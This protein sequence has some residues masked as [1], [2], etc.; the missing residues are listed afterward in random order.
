MFKKKKELQYDENIVR[1]GKPYEEDDFSF[2]IRNTENSVLPMGLEVSD[3]RYIIIDGKYISMYALF[4]LPYSA[5]ESFFDEL[6]NL[7]EGIE[8]FIKHKC[9]NKQK[10]IKEITQYIG[11]TKVKIEEGENQIDSEVMNS[12]L[13]HSQYLKKGLANGNEFYYIYPIVRVIADS[14]EELKKKDAK[15]ESLLSGKDITAKRADFKN[16]ETFLTAIPALN[17]DKGI[18]NAVE[19]NILSNDLAGLYPFTNASISDD[20]GIYLGTNM[21][22]KSNV[23]I[24]LFNTNKYMNANTLIFGGSGSGKT[25]TT[26][27]IMLRMRME[28][29]PV[30]MIAPFKGFEYKN[31]CMA[32]DGNYIKF[33]AGS[34]LGLNIMDIR[35]YQSENNESYLADKI[36]F[37]KIILDMMI[38]EIKARELR[39]IE[40]PI[41]KT[42]EDFGINMDNLSIYE[43]SDRLNF[44][45]KVKKM[46]KLSDLQ[47]NIEK[48]EEVKHIAKSL[49]PYVTGSLSFFNKDTNF[50]IEN[51]YNIADISDLSEEVMQI[52]M[53]AILEFFLYRV[54]RNLKEKDIIVIDEMWKLV[55]INEQVATYILELYKIV[56]G[57][58][59]SVI[60]ATQD[61]QDCFV[62]N[63]GYYGKGLLNNSSIK[64]LLKCDHTSTKMLKDALNLTSEEAMRIEKFKRGEGL[65]FAGSNHLVVDFDAFDEE[66]M[67]I[68][69]DVNERR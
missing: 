52:A 9:E 37:L 23:N 6:V 39:A 12:A 44:N 57:Y 18:L 10:I 63:D 48:D 38:P 64:I 25:F 67:L 31:L 8:L 62:L 46:P 17:E 54:R 42:Y 66:K 27:M 20:N 28:K 50:D 68:T 3:H 41:L 55:A 1:I 16:L 49:D 53:F 29:M 43:E 14:F 32:V 30:F 47:K 56:R 4:N 19:R 58:G 11:F 59:C 15:V 2:E 13:S 34:E 33:A 21:H 5:S 51:L 65:V 36:K 26:Q 40:K 45:Q 61:I 22:D 35:P 60:G 7:D 24:D 69:T